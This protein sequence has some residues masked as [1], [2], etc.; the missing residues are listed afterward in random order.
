MRDCQILLQLMDILHKVYI[1]NRRGTN[2][3][4]TNLVCDG[5]ITH[6]NIKKKQRKLGVITVEL[7]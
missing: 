5:T 3:C 2:I 6:G 7:A 4:L 1:K